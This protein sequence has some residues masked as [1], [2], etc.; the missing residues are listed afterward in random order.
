MKLDRTLQEIEKSINDIVDIEF[1][2]DGRGFEKPTELSLTNAVKIVKELLK[3]VDSDDCPWFSPF[4]YSNEDGYV[5]IGWQDKGKALHFHIKN[6]DMDYR[7]IWNSAN[8]VKSGSEKG[9][10]NPQICLSL[11]E[12]LI[13]EP[14]F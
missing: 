3:Q 5:C 2:W 10:L 7:K 8:N 11:W 1:D 4:A 12:W 14:A 6:D 9:Y 13:I